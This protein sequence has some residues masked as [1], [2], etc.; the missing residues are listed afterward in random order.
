MTNMLTAPAATRAAGQRTGSPW[1]TLAVVLTGQFMAVLDAAVVNVAAPSIHAE[2]HASG[3][4]LQLVIAGYVITYAVLLVTGA[5][6]GDML[7]HRRVFLG[8][9]ML[10]T[11]TSLGCGLAATT[12]Q[13]V[14][15]RFLQGAGAAAMIPQVLSLIQR[16][17]TGAA[18][19]RPM[20]LY[21]AVLA[22]GVA[23]GQVVGGLLVSA[24]LLGSGWRPVFLLNVPIG[25]VLLAVGARVLPRGGGDPGRRLDL[26]GVATLTPAVLALVLPLVL[27]QSEHWPAWVWACLA[28]SVV[29]FGVFT[30]VQRQVGRA[31]GSPLIPGR[32]VRLP[33]V[34]AG[35]AALFA[36]MAV[37]GGFFFVLALH[38]QGGL[39]DSPLRAGLIFVP[40][41]LAFTLV[42][43]NWQRVPPA[44]HLALTCGGFA[45][46]AAGLLLLG[47]LLSGGASGG[48]W[49]YAAMALTGG[50]MAAAF[51]PLMTSVVMR[52]PVAD[53]SEAT[54]VIVTVNQ[55]GLL[56]GV[57]T[58][59][60]F[61][62]NLA[63]RLPGQPGTGGFRL[64]SAHAMS[65]TCLA[66][67]AA[68][69]AGGL[70]ALARAARTRRWDAAAQEAAV[71]GESLES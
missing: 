34:A 65:L 36:M 39:G 17:F 7:G 1:G 13:L 27:G 62:L 9:L 71:G 35:V 21:S 47:G 20:R 70:L 28:G 2:L 8:G 51:G 48:G 44:G 6:L 30:L 25:A 26:A 11:L 32:L 43:L 42:S 5:R 29:L 57:A 23:A 24:N 60:T 3:A 61:Y 56:I 33:G 59:G 15:L 53:A 69:A 58:F 45:S 41:G 49:T 37:F 64:L 10:F 4:G 55:L 18:R 52:V 68:A 12:G 46:Y 16:S 40:A 50:G 31:G 54:G 66:L 67:A 38:L 19:A 14:T 22:G 63:G